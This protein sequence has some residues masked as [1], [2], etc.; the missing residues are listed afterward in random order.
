MGK[1]IYLFETRAK[2]LIEGVHKKD[3]FQVRSSTQSVNLI[4]GSIGMNPLLNLHKPMDDYP[5]LEQPQ[6]RQVKQ[7]SW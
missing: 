7:P 4:V 3:G 1:Q 6:V 5:H 2:W